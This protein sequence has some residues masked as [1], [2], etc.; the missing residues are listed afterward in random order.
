MDVNGQLHAPAALLPGKKAQIP[1][2]EEV[3][4]VPVPV[5]TLRLRGKFLSLPETELRSF[6]MDYFNCRPQGGISLID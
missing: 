1:I 5:W 2:A 4:W 3:G 6:V